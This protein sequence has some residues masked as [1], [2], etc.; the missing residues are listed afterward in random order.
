MATLQ[1]TATRRSKH[2]F[3]LSL[4]NKLQAACQNLSQRRWNHHFSGWILPSSSSSQCFP[5][6]QSVL[7]VYQIVT[8]ITRLHFKIL[9]T[10]RLV[11]RWRRDEYGKVSVQWGETF[12]WLF[13]VQMDKENDDVFKLFIQFGSYPL[14]FWDICL[15]GFWIFIHMLCIR[16]PW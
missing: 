7:D 4:P 1:H 14:R 12:K 16:L 10:S 2:I 3:I 9:S 13:N 5:L 11:Q 8:A 15:W 6:S